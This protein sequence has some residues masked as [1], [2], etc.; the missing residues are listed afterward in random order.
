MAEEAER[1][2]KRIFLAA[3]EII[4]PSER[5]AYLNQACGDD[6]GL[7]NRVEEL[8]RAADG[9]GGIVDKLPEEFV[10]TDLMPT[11]SEK[12]G[13]TVGRYKLME[14]IGEG[15][16]GLVFVAEQQQPV[17]RKVAL[18]IIKPGMD[19]KD[20][21]ARFEAERQA[22]ALMDHPNIAKVLDAGTTESGHPYFVMELVR[23]VPITQYC[24]TNQLTTRERLELFV[25]VCR[26]VQHAHQK[27]IIHRD[28]KPTN[29][30]V[31][32]HD[33]V[34]VVKVIDFGVA[35]ALHQPLTERTI[36]TRFAQ[37]IGTPIYMSP[38]QAE[39]SGLDIDTRSDIYSL[40]VLLYELLTGT[41]PLTKERLAQ[42]AYNE[43]VRMIREEEP[44]V[45]STRLS[46]SGE[47]LA[48]IAAQRK[49]EPGKLS[50]L[51]RGDLD[52]ITMK[53]L[54]KDRTRRYESASGFAADVLRYLA[55]EAVEAS[56]PS[57]WY[58]LRK[59][60]RK[61]RGAI[62]TAGLVMGVLIAGVV[63]SSVFAIREQAARGVADRNAQKANEE[64]EKAEK[65]RE[66]AE[67][68]KR[69]ADESAVKE[70]E[71]AKK[72]EAAAAGER[73][74]REEIA[75]QLTRNLMEKGVS[76]C[77]A[78]RVDVGVAYL[79]KAYQTLVKAES[80]EVELRKSLLRLLGAWLEELPQER[81]V[82]R[83][84]RGEFELPDRSKMLR[85]DFSKMPEEFQRGRRCHVFANSH[86][87]V[88]RGHDSSFR[89]WNLETGEKIG[90]P[91]STLGEEFD[92]S[93][94]GD[95]TRFVSVIGNESQVWNP[96]TGEKVGPAI[97]V[98]TPVNSIVLD[99]NGTRLLINSKSK[100]E[101]QNQ[102]SVWSIPDGKLVLNGIPDD[103]VRIGGIYI[104]RR[105]DRIYTSAEGKATLW[106]IG[107]GQA[108]GE[109]FVHD[110][111]TD[112]GEY[113]PTEGI[114]Y[115]SS[116]NHVITAHNGTVG[117]RSLQNGK[118]IGNSI[119]T[120]RII[121][122]DSSPDGSRLVT[123]SL[124]GV[125]TWTTITGKKLS[126]ILSYPES[127]SICT[128][129]SFFPDGE[130]VSVRTG[131]SGRLIFDSTSGKRRYHYP[132]ETDSFRS[133]AIGIPKYCDD[134]V[135]IDF[136]LTDTGRIVDDLSMGKNAEWLVATNIP[137]QIVGYHRSAMQRY[138]LAEGLAT[139]KSVPLA[140][141]KFGVE[142][143]IASNKVQLEFLN[144]KR[145]PGWIKI[146]DSSSGEVVNDRITIESDSI[147]KTRGKNTISRPG[148]ESYGNLSSVETLFTRDV[149]QFTDDRVFIRDSKRDVLHEFASAKVR[150][151]SDNSLFLVWGSGRT[152][153]SNFSDKLEIFD[154][155]T[156]ER[157]TNIAT[158]RLPR[159]AWISPNKKFVL[160]VFFDFI[161]MWDAGTGQPFKVPI[162]IESDMLLSVSRS[163]QTVLLPVR[164]NVLQAYSTDTFEPIGPPT[165]VP[166]DD[167]VYFPSGDCLCF[168]S[169]HDKKP[170]IWNVE[171]GEKLAIPEFTMDP[172]EDP[173][174][175]MK[176][177]APLCFWK[178]RRGVVQEMDGTVRIWDLDSGKLLRE[179]FQANPSQV[180]VEVGESHFGFIDLEG[181][182]N[183]IHTT[184]GRPVFPAI[185]PTEGVKEFAASGDGRRV[186][187]VGSRG[188]VSFWN[189]ETGE[190]ISGPHLHEGE[191]VLVKLQ[192]KPYRALTKSGKT[193][194]L[195]D[196][197]SGKLECEPIVMDENF[198]EFGFSEDGKHAYASRSA[199][200]LRE[201]EYELY[202]L[203][204][205][206]AITDR[207]PASARRRKG[208]FSRD[209]ALFFIPE[210]EV[211]K[212]CNVQTGEVLREIPLKEKE[213]L[214]ICRWDGKL[215]W[216]EKN[217]EPP[218]T[219]LVVGE[220]N[221]PPRTLFQVGDTFLS[222][223]IVPEISRVVLKDWSSRTNES[224]QIHLLDWE[225]GKQICPPIDS[226]HY[227]GS[228][229]DW[230]EK[231]PCFT[232]DGK[233]FFSVSMNQDVHQHTDKM[234]G[235]TFI[236]SHIKQA[237]LQIRDTETGRL[238]RDLVLL[239]SNIS[240]IAV[241]PDSK[242]LA[243]ARPF[244]P[245]QMFDLETGTPFGSGLLHSDRAKTV[246]FSPDGKKLVTSDE[247]GRVRVFSVPR[248]LPD[249]PWF[250]EMLCAD[251]SRKIVD[252]NQFSSDFNGS[253]GDG[254]IFDE[255]E[256][257]ELGKG[258]FAEQEAELKARIRGWQIHRA[259]TTFEYKNYSACKFHLDQIAGDVEKIPRLMA[260]RGMVGAMLDQ[261]DVSVRDIERALSMGGEDSYLLKELAWFFATCQEDRCRDGK[262]G[263]EFALKGCELT[264][265]KDGGIIDTLAATYA[266]V[267][268]FEKAVEMENK[269][270]E[271]RPEENNKEFL[272]RLELYR[273]KKPYRDV[274]TESGV[275]AESRE[276][277]VESR[278]GTLIDKGIEFGKGLL[279]SLKVKPQVNSV[280]EN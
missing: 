39:M 56:P 186:V 93:F 125:W 223:K 76:E 129:V 177:N 127:P 249:V 48:T 183:V 257:V 41:T 225:T 198:S 32:L 113:A 193:L 267:G 276:E 142:P 205:G 117:V 17:R 238:V 264:E 25:S 65:E 187:T 107:T 55:D 140:A 243:I 46:Q 122:F 149:L 160:G 27:G 214:D 240:D 216:L 31:T 254:T 91:I 139:G 82:D 64:A 195:W 155:S 176:L 247:S 203:S 30:L 37:M 111:K 121:D 250:V 11:V 53:A 128:G 83:V 179:E 217:N 260:L 97:K 144:L 188:E 170:H 59:T 219:S 131:E 95:G 229:F 62:V 201:S 168:I 137:D 150:K 26:A 255:K 33:G 180:A 202:D 71:A 256:F 36:Y 92:W 85:I 60:A 228:D 88:D 135:R 184:D 141:E 221:S 35:K 280:P 190:L 275:A 235:I 199:A 118:I 258:W 54:E 171:T 154:L 38:E 233:C 75:V 84:W 4:D 251:R 146:W 126:K 105:G 34:P 279:D 151:S 167:C 138:S 191:E 210:G 101:G 181:G 3:F 172:T 119:K 274:P 20:V 206:S 87:A 40:G 44:P 13:T 12:V 166:A 136:P 114:K 102:I 73:T 94:S 29:V 277:K 241:S 270:I 14:Q 98:Q 231:E 173:K 19:T 244:E 148:S 197:E 215:F 8:L 162:Q 115:S 271:L 239:H 1:E 211:G 272:E 6:E 21:V 218:V 269:A 9:G 45:P 50:K 163:Q 112:Y 278:G 58:R 133:I 226:P 262:R 145:I 22:L 2:A 63:A 266:E 153:G 253:M 161:R 103:L 124:E 204:E 10:P 259:W 110:H 57:R 234:R 69:A 182:C 159:N 265:W 268:E 43:L 212:I 80:K 51:V 230:I 130:Q 68:A 152:G 28:I 209:G 66:K 106:D 213:V 245:V 196:L 47:A 49:S 134:G 224:E 185:R 222:G 261:R 24:D 79:N 15:G 123:Q 143:K 96:S 207:F 178:T 89:F 74:A 120:G 147:A 157:R 108:V 109:S 227:P 67:V 86:I 169:R 132:T 7:K 252:E 42:A 99:P 174:G 189:G 23:G 242:L 77:T 200:I 81:E 248:A 18:K 164:K 165:F 100:R 52:W 104:N 116:G 158:P 61:Y 5:Q 232:P 220:Q 194:R 208:R 192:G 237:N 246:C 90:D 72:A 16:F 273:A 70:A 78:G 263:V 175:W 236:D 156:G